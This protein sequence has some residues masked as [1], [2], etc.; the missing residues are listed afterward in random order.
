MRADTLIS[1]FCL[2]SFC[3]IS[4]VTSNGN[5]TLLLPD[6][7]LTNSTYRTLR[8]ISDSTLDNQH[9]AI[10][11]PSGSQ[12]LDGGSGFTIDRSYEGI[13]VWSDGNEWFTV[14]SKNL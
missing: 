3:T 9:R 10:I 1:L 12:T 8:F 13:M 5:L 14:Q 11:T 7:T 2:I 6:A 4:V